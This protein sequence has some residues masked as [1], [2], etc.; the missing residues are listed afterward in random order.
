MARSK[1]FE[2]DR[3]DL[4]RLG[5]IVLIAAGLIWFLITIGTFSNASVS[6][7]FT[8]WPVLLIGLGLDIFLGRSG[9]MGLPY[10]VF[11]VAVLILVMF[12]GPP[13][14]LSRGP[15]VVTET[16]VEP[17]GNAQSA[18]INLDLASAPNQ[19]FS[20]DGGGELVNAELTHTGTINFTARGDVNKV[21]ELSRSFEGTSFGFTGVLQT[22]WDIG[23]S[24][25]IPID[26]F[27]DVGSGPVQLELARLD[28]SDFALSGGSGPVQL[29]LPASQERYQA[30]IDGGSGPIK[31]GLSDRAELGLTVDVGSGPF[32]ATLGRDLDLDLSLTGGSG[33]I[34]IDLPGGA[35]VKVEAWDDGSGPLTVGGGLQRISGSDD[36]GVWQTPGFDQADRQI[37]IT[38]RR[39][40]SGPITIR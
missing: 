8:Y 37:L 30:E 40:G 27:V 39:A 10:T 22:R 33:P 26:L 31:L 9:P 28:L 16:F 34:R 19:I 24:P 5:A 23:L 20:L 36:T 32:T 14:G 29:E 7:L 17:L 12:I 21:V 1:T 13:L 4:P 3:L 15:N 38:V 35:E 11:A 25:D 6:I 18:R 2:N